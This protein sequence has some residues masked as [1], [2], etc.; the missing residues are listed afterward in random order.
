MPNCLTAES[1]GTLVTVNKPNC[2]GTYLNIQEAPRRPPVNNDVQRKRLPL[3]N[4]KLLDFY[5]NKNL[6]DMYKALNDW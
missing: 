6:I 2:P 5:R 4:Y 1:T 3:V